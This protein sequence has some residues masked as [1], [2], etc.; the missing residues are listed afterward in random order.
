MK[1]AEIVFSLVVFAVHVILIV[2]ESISK[3]SCLFV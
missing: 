3:T 2:F 1:K